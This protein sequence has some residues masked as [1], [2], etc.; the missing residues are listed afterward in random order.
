MANLTF[1][2]SELIENVLNMRGGYFLDFTNRQFKSFMEKVVSYDVYIKY[3]NLSKAEIF[4]QFIEDET[5]GYVGKALISALLYMREKNLINESNLED[6]NKLQKLGNRLLGRTIKQSKNQAEGIN[7][8]H[9]I[10]YDSLSKSLL[11]IDKD[12]TNQQARGYAFEKYLNL[13]FDSFKL[14]PR[15]SYK[16]QNDQIDGSFT[17]DGSTILVEA[18]YRKSRIPKDDLVIFTN[19]IA[20][21]SHFPKGLFVTLTPL[22]DIVLNYFID[23]SARVIVLTVEEIYLL[24]YDKLSLPQVL[25]AKFRVLDEQGLIFKHILTLNL[26]ND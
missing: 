4:R 10:D 1:I 8:N 5:E 25:R 11:S 6:C 22:D 7:E 9:T 24:C 2:E 17:L 15:A 16:A 23:K 14:E 20:S 26:N 18:K 13:L 21:K 12:F 19:K 3:P